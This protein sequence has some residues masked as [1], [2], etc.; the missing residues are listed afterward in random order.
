[1]PKMLALVLRYEGACRRAAVQ[2][3]GYK[4]TSHVYK[5]KYEADNAL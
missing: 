5:G 2:N 1:M 3:Q 4:H